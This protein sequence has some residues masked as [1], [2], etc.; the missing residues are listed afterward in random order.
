LQGKR[1]SA[2]AALV[3]ALVIFGISAAD[4]ALDNMVTTTLPLLGNYV[5]GLGTVYGGI[6]VAVYGGAEL[7]TNL[8]VN[9]RL[10][11]R[12]RRY[13]FLGSSAGIAAIC[14]LFT[15]AG[16]AAALALAAL[17]G[18]TTSIIAQNVVVSASST[19]DR[20]LG[21]RNLAFYTVGLSVSLVAGPS[22]ESYLLTL[23]YDAV[24]LGFAVLGVLVFTLSLR[25][26]LTDI[27]GAVRR[28]GPSA[29]RG[30]R[31]AFL[32][33]CSFSIPLAA[34]VTLLPIYSSESFHVSAA[35]AYSS[36]VPMYAVSL[37]VRLFM[38][39]RPF[40]RLILPTVVSM[41]LTLAA[42]AGMYFAP[43]F[44]VLLVMMALLGIPHGMAFAIALILVARTSDTAERSAVNSYLSAYLGVV[45]IVVPIAVGYLSVAVGVRVSFLLLLPPT[46]AVT[47][48][49][50]LI[51]ARWTSLTSG[52][53]E[54]G[55]SP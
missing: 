41:L 45:G 37:A 21:E 10:T 19:D 28:P 42:L 3:G 5:F 55:R 48:A 29:R 53:Q 27:G 54:S 39:A 49:Y 34:F 31:S 44:F 9:P 40:T 24:F 32:T 11:K 16:P 47:L 46:A 23:G 50:L 25:I 4:R 43:S 15:V 1:E 13:V 14:V 35:E 12:L 2:F 18:V 6:A 26:K 17:A 36:F 7:L 20:R 52:G 8:F 33:A 22:L 30:L 51:Y 38:T